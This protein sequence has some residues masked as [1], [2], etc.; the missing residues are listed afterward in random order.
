VLYDDRG[1]G[2][3]SIA[4]GRFVPFLSGLLCQWAKRPTAF[5]SSS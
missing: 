2:I 5:S 1:E 3:G 4:A